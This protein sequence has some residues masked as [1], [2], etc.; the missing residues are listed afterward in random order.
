[1][2]W[3]LEWHFIILIDKSNNTLLIV[4]SFNYKKEAQLLT[5]EVNWEER[6]CLV[7]NE[8]DNQGHIY[9]RISSTREKE[10]IINISNFSQKLYAWDGRLYIIATFQHIK[11]FWCHPK[12]T[13]HF[14][15]SSP[16]TRVHKSYN[17]TL[18]PSCQR[19][20]KA[21]TGFLTTHQR[22]F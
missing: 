19:M 16:N 18:I 14:F 11:Y 3:K 13:G 4:H 12:R 15:L 22:L 8:A 20:C 9:C 5:A 10:D 2:C 17:D 1:M 6:L 7:G 21:E